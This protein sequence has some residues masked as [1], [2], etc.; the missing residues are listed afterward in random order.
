MGRQSSVYFPTTRISRGRARRSEYWYF[1]LF[2]GIVMLCLSLLALIPGAV[3]LTV[4]FWLGTVVPNLAVSWRR[5]HDT[6]RSG[7]WVFLSLVPLV[8]VLILILWMAEDSQPGT[9]PF[10]PNPKGTQATAARHEGRNIPQRA[11]VQVQC[12][13]G[14]MQGQ[15]FSLGPQGLWFGR[16]AACAVRFPDGTP[17]ISRVHCRLGWDRGVPVLVDLNSR[18][19]TF[20]VSGKQLPPQLSG[21]CFPRRPVLPGQPRQSLSNHLVTRH[22]G[23][24][25]HGRNPTENHQLQPRPLLRRQPVR[26]LPLLQFRQFSLPRWTPSH[27]RP[28]ASAPRWAWRG[29]GFPWAKTMGGSAL[30]SRPSSQ[31]AFPAPWG[32][33]SMWT[34]PPRRG[35]LPLWW[36]GCSGKRPL[37]WYGLPHPHRVQLHRP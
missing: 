10:G 19:G 3:L 2:Y 8:G 35:P 29:P 15:T 33:P 20:L 21:S 9:N 11:A 7:A 14:P 27:L 23:G 17:G 5:L 24:M 4:I 37:P 22:A 28:R 32:R 30:R 26:Q 1:V 36:D 12:I 34:L 18:F 16:D 13:N 31:S 25:N 6:G